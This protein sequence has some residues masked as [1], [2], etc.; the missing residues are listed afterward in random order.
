MSD[1]NG[2]PEWLRELGAKVDKLADKVDQLSDTVGK[3][4]TTVSVLHET[5]KHHEGMLGEIVVAF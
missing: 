2:F 3:L 1:T 5:A 4:N